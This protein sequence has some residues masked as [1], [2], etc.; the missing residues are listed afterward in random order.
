MSKHNAITPA[1]VYSFDRSEKPKTNFE[2]YGF[3]FDVFAGNI[4]YD[5]KKQKSVIDNQ[6]EYFTISFLTDFGYIRIESLSFYNKPSEEEFNEKLKDKIGYFEKLSKE[7][8]ADFI[9]AKIEI[10]KDVS[11]YESEQAIAI[12]ERKKQ[13]EIEAL[14]KEQAEKEKARLKA[15]EEEKELLQSEINFKE[16]R[17]ISVYHFELLCKKYGIKMAISTIGAIRRCY[18]TIGFSGGTI[19]KKTNCEKHWTAA[20]ELY[21]ILNA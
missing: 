15:I 4:W 20:K 1:K 3:K 21:K 13:R 5:T 7:Q 10:L 18:K 17:A 12:T 11:K 19:T 14:E 8:I 9:N 6:E 16:N 2:V